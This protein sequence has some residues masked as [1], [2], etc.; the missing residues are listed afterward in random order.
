MVG[1]TNHF[2]GRLSAFKV[3]W[4]LYIRML[5]WHFKFEVNQI[6]HFPDVKLLHFGQI[7]VENKV[8]L[9]LPS[10]SEHLVPQWTYVVQLYGKSEGSDNIFKTI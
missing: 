5:S 8:H 10:K 3:L 7:T 4:L 2:C 9:A 1:G 6:S